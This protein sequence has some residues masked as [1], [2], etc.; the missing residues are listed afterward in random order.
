[1]KNSYEMF[2]AYPNSVILHQWLTNF[3][4]LSYNPFMTL[5][6]LLKNGPSCTWKYATNMAPHLRRKT[7]VQRKA[8]KKVASIN[9]RNYAFIN[10]YQGKLYLK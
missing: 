1:M 8:H 6:F 7:K 2:L 9:C 4:I 10:N 3:S 5:E